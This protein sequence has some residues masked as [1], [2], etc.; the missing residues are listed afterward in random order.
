[1]LPSLLK[2][3][4]LK[5]KYGSLNSVTNKEFTLIKKYFDNEI[6]NNFAI[7]I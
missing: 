1:M 3:R 6:S 2:S 4:G 5:E 7:Y